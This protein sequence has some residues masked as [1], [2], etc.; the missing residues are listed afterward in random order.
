MDLTKKILQSIHK[1]HLIKTGD[2]LV[3]G[4]SGGADSITLLDVL[5]ELRHALGI[6]ICV[7]HCNHHLR[8]NSDKDELLVRKFVKKLN[9]PLYVYH[10]KFFST[11]ESVS[12]DAARQWRFE[13]FLKVAKKVKAAAIVLAH[14]QNDLAETVLMRLLRGTGLSGLRGIVLENEMKG[15]KFLRPFLSISRR[16]IE[17]YLKLQKLEFCVDETNLQ[18]HYL[19][20]KIRLKLLP[21][22]IKEYNSNLPEILIDLAHNS[23]ADY[24]YIYCE[25]KQLFQSHAKISKAN[26]RVSL[27]VF[28]KWPLSMRR[29]FLRLSFE[30]LV[31]DLNQLSFKHIQEVENLIS[32]RPIGAE[33]AWPKAIIVRK[34]KDD[35]GIKQMLP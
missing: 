23:Q 20:N 18:T 9:L 13:C 7:V 28:S 24:D 14:T 5:H 12:E 30:Y 15:I 1:V 2:V 22:L 6:K 31:G 11:S 19:R 27:E 35:L 25:A 29:M 32:S 34:T 26:V 10:R 3:V 33:V 21:S 16:E 8:T 4:V 17:Q